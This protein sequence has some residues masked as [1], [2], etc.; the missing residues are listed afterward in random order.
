VNAHDVGCQRTVRL[1]YNLETIASEDDGGDVKSDDKIRRVDA[2]TC[3]I[4]EWT[5]RKEWAEGEQWMD[6]ALSS[7]VC[8]GRLRFPP[9]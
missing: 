3:K 2:A 6:S 8:G 4:Q 7:F 9:E 1:R 5:S